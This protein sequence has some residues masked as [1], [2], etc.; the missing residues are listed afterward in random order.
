MAATLLLADDSVTIQRMIELTFA[1]EW[2]HVVTVSDGD[3][4]TA[5]LE[6]ERPDIVL[7]DVGLP[8]VDGYDIAERIKRSPALSSTPI[9]LLT[10]AFDPIDE[11][12]ARAT[13]CD[14]VLVKPFDPR[15]LIGVVKGLL[16][17]QRPDNLW[18]T[19]MPRID[20]PRRVGHDGRQ[21]RAAEAVRPADPGQ[22][23]S[24]DPGP[25]PSPPVVEEVFEI[26]LDD[27][28]A[29]FSRL[30]PVAPA[31]RLDAET[32]SDFRRDIQE[33]RSAPPSP[34]AAPVDMPLQPPSAMGPAV[35]HL[36]V[37]VAT[38]ADDLDLDWD[39]SPLPSEQ[40][41]PEAA[42][43]RGALDA[44]RSRDIEEVVRRVVTRMTDEL[45]RTLMSET[46]ER[47]IRE[48]MDKLKR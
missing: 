45:V 43:A 10:G 48:E 41:Q 47:L 26:G 42:D 12:R 34:S 39:L 38:P 16:A 40:A 46:A 21:L 28:D 6:D 3:A 2:I 15:H 33:L 23:A 22:P 18:P 14:G 36:P 24:G 1:S 44:A 8:A 4:A 35:T 13:G 19:D 27:L 17:G 30:D 11:A 20:A 7:A 31:S 29:A 32:V 25:L 5:R 9:L 37:E